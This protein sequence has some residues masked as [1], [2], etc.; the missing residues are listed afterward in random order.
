MKTKITCHIICMLI[1]NGAILGL[2]SCSNDDSDDLYYMGTSP[3][4]RNIKY[5][6][7]MQQNLDIFLPEDSVESLAP[8]VI[9]VHG[10]G[11][12]GGDKSEWGEEMVKT[13]RE[14]GY[15]SVSLNYRLVPSVVYPENLSDVI[16]GIDWVYTHI[17]DYHGNPHDITLVG[18]SAGT[19]LVSSV[20]CNQKYIKEANFDCHDIH[21]VCLL[22]GGGYLAMQNVIY[23]DEDIYAIVNKALGGNQDNWVDFGP[24]NSISEC[25]YIPPMVICHSDDGYR[26]RANR[27]F[28]KKLNEYGFGSTEYTLE[29]YTHFGI[30]YNFPYFN[31]D[32]DVISH[33]LR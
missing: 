30:L 18:H 15:L 21:L 13:F 7:N 6:D 28:I 14:L 29:G 9:Y 8:V 2:S 4:E 33:F 31:N 22:D 23:E 1:L 24:A 5:G 25:E 27:E 10:G 20:V 16:N 26:I 12:V 17:E 3:N 32:Y 19:Q 11:W